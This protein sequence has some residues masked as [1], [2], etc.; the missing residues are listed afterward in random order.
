ML[1]AAA[2]HAI[3]GIVVKPHDPRHLRNFRVA[4]E[5]SGPSECR[6][7]HRRMVCRRSWRSQCHRIAVTGRPRQCGRFAPGGPVG[8]GFSGSMRR[9]LFDVLDPLRCEGSPLAQPVEAAR[10]ALGDVELCR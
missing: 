2:A 5:G 4:D 9:H 3:E 1:A 10:R 6:I 7:G 8:A